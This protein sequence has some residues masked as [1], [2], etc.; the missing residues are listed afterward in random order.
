M[1]GLTTKATNYNNNIYNKRVTKFTKQSHL[2]DEATQTQKHQFFTTS[3]SLYI[4]LYLQQK[5]NQKKM[6]SNKLTVVAV[7]NEEPRSGIRRHELILTFSR[8]L[9]VS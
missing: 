8:W 4:F 5:T 2:Y 3:C 7:A 9:A 1:E 6:L